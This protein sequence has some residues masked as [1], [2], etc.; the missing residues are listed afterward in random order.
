MSD[1]TKKLTSTEKLGQSVIG[2]FQP[3]SK[4][5]KQ[6]NEKGVKID[7]PQGSKPK[8]EID[9]KMD[10]DQEHSALLLNE[11]ELQ[12][13]KLKR[14]KSDITNQLSHTDY[15]YQEKKKFADLS[16]FQLVSTIGKGAYGRVMLVERRSTNE[17]YAMKIVRFNSSVDKE[18]LQDL[19]NEKD[20]FSMVGGDHVVK[21]YFTFSH[22]NYV[23]FVMEFMP[24]GDFDGVLKTQ[25][26][27]EQTEEAPFYA[28]ELVLAI[29][30]LHSKNIVHRD[31]KPQ[32]ILLDKKGHLKLADFGLSKAQSKYRQNIEQM[33]EQDIFK[34]LV[35]E[36]NMEY[37]VEIQIQKVRNTKK[38]NPK[39]K[40]PREEH[41]Q[42]DKENKQKKLTGDDKKKNP[43]EEDNRIVGTPDY[44]PPEVLLGYSRPEFAKAIDWW[45]LGCIIYEFLLG[46][47]PFNAKTPE[48]VFENIKAY[49][50]EG[51]YEIEL[52][53]IGDDE[54]CLSPAA[55]DI[56]NK[57]LDIDPQKRLGTGGAD[58][59]KNHPFFEF[60]DWENIRKTAPPLE[61][62]EIT[63]KDERRMDIK[64]EEIF[65]D[66]KNKN[67]GTGSINPHDIEL[68]RVDLLHNDN[69]EEFKRYSH[70]LEVAQKQKRE[71]YEK[72]FEF[73]RQGLF[74][75]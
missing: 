22:K 71:A 51:G 53:P 58:E 54:G 8:L 13:S 4:L 59:I 14:S 62:Q 66:D 34:D 19:I 39:N 33:N 45:A 47:P 44:I 16:D 70:A 10:A 30:Y 29:D 21:A 69:T 74:I 43:L 41:H 3:S 11:E 55:F 6:S 68:F 20:I 52:P 46:F 12:K 57:L 1:L 15:L 49:K 67:K 73:E 61:V 72:M 25:E 7:L 24:G 37:T 75:V 65:K 40:H 48:A 17:Q 26:F 36:E 50:R 5:P 35:S 28:A 9:V 31:L 27:L 56:I 60:I 64:L 63:I 42:V 2:N 38:N 23:I 18:A 32:N